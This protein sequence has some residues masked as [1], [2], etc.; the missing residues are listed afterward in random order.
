MTFLP[1]LHTDRSRASAQSVPS[2][3]REIGAGGLQILSLRVG[4]THV[5]H[6]SGEFDLTAEEG[7]LTE[8]AEVAGDAP[9]E[10]VLD[11]GDV[12]FMDARGLLALVRA[13]EAVGGTALKISRSSQAVRRIVELTDTSSF[14]AR[15]TRAE[16]RR[17][18]H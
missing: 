9:T 6:L 12:D 5:L 16:L 10:I 4:A 8:I 11:L 1:A 7:F 15:D 18:R 2:P 13:S 14:M 17:G 3:A